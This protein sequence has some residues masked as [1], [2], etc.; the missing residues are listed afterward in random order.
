MTSSLWKLRNTNSSRNL[1]IT[2]SYWNARYGW[3]SHDP[4]KRRGWIKLSVSSRTR[5][6]P[7]LCIGNAQLAIQ[8]NSEPWH[9]YYSIYSLVSF[10]ERPSKWI[11]VNKIPPSSPPPLLPN[12]T[13]LRTT[14]LLI[15]SHYYSCSRVRCTSLGFHGER[16]EIRRTAKFNNAR[17]F[18]FHTTSYIGARLW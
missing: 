18:F 12:N 2:P 13:S 1:E 7:P 4:L 11:N 17:P 16:F 15:T 10:T 5:G 14:F 6:G 3:I 9:A 8:G